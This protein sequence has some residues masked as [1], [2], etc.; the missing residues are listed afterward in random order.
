MPRT[1]SIQNSELLPYK[2]LVGSSISSPINIAISERILVLHLYY[3]GNPNLVLLSFHLHHVCKN[4]FF[5]I[6]YV[7][8]HIVETPKYAWNP[9]LEPQASDYR[10]NRKPRIHTS[11][12]TGFECGGSEN[13]KS[14]C[15]T[16]I[17]QCNS[18]YLG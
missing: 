4:S 16:F 15:G 13:I 10:P 8:R 1:S 5:A 6:L 9:V 17:L 18:D 2:T 12:D 3:G 14:G 11:H 7:V